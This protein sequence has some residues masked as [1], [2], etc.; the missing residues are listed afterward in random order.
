VRSCQSLSIIEQKA[1]QIEESENYEIHGNRSKTFS[2]HGLQDVYLRNLLVSLR[3]SFRQC[4]A[5][6]GLL[7]HAAVMNKLYTDRCG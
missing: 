7:G 3:S 6:V 1:R 2:S 5:A 4:A